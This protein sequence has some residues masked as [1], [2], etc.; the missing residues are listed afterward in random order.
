MKLK[1]LYDEVIRIGIENDPRQKKDIDELLE[2]RKKEYEK[3]SN[4]D[5]EYFDKETLTN[6]YSDSRI[7]A[8][9]ASGQIKK[10][11]VGID[12][13]T[14]ELLLAHT[15]NQQ[16]SGIDLVLSHHPIGRALVTFYEV[17]DLQVDVFN[18]KGISLSAAEKLLRGRKSRV[19][20]E[21]SSANFSKAKDAA[22][23][24]GLSL[25]CAHTPADNSGYKFLE[26]TFSKNKPRVLKDI[27]DTLLELDEY[28]EASR[29][30]CPPRIINGS[31][32]SRVKN[33]QYE[34]TGGTE[35]PEGIYEKLSSSGVDTIVAMH[36]SE[37]HFKAAKEAN[38]NIVLAG[39]IASDNLG[40]NL[41]L[42]KLQKK[43][44]FDVLSCSGF[45][46]FSHR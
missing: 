35:G 25:M 43:F 5:K 13:N 46:R 42:D 32:N 18:Q 24:L 7:I 6:P 2:R 29:E 8:G 44:K 27:V 15:L 12:I 1:N 45:K 17:M 41:L 39:H 21:V 30:G 4:S 37:E 36:L 19:E 33:I 22:E 11:L 40:V 28:K 20:R 31:P 14:A 3:L 34:F 26:R 23:L 16:G 9:S 10:V 38:L